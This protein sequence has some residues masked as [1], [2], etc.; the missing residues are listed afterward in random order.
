MHFVPP[1]PCVMLTKHFHL[2]RVFILLSSNIERGNGVAGTYS[3]GITVMT[4]LPWLGKSQGKLDF[5][6][7]QGKV[8]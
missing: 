8:R 2:T 6:Q 3:V 7:G 4:G 1:H 5:L